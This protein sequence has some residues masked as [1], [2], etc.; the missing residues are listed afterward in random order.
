MVRGL[1]LAAADVAGSGLFAGG[2]SFAGEVFDGAGL[3]AGAAA[4]GGAA[5]ARV[6]AAGGTARVAGRAAGAGAW[7]AACCCVAAGSAAAPSAGAT[8]AGAVVAADGGSG[9]TDGGGLTVVE[10]AGS[11]DTGTVAWA[12]GDGAAALVSV[13]AVGVLAAGRSA[14]TP[15]MSARYRTTPKAIFSPVSGPTTARTRRSRPAIT[16]S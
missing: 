14:A 4:A 10:R 12:V 15:M 7:V 13:V 1:Q 9:L 11:A 3:F 16:R 6:A 8:A 2:A 5:G